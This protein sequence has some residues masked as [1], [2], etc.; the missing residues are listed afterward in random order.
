MSAEQRY[1]FNRVSIHYNRMYNPECFLN[2][3]PYLASVMD[4]A[5][6]NYELVASEEFLNRCQEESDLSSS[7]LSCRNSVLPAYPMVH[8]QS[9]QFR[10]YLKE[11][12]RPYAREKL[13]L[14]LNND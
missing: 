7:L 12:D 1:I 5:L 6:M 2:A 11:V 14:D 4:S 10:Q 9:K 8:L 3:G 13:A